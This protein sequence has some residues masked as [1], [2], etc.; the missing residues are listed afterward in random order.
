MKKCQLVIFSLFQYYEFKY[1]LNV[2][3]VTG[4]EFDNLTDKKCWLS[5]Y[6]SKIL[7]IRSNIRFSN[8]K[9]K[10]CL[11]L[12]YT[13]YP[14]MQGLFSYDDSNPTDTMY[15]LFGAKATQLMP[16]L[17]PGNSATQLLSWIS[18]TRTEGR[19]PHSPVTRYRPSSDL[20]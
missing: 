13:L 20:K 18:Q 12:K 10:F 11:T 3:Y 4:R 1:F 8:Q 5:P 9:D 7:N 17:W 2:K 6:I 15:L 14:C 19:W 16:Y